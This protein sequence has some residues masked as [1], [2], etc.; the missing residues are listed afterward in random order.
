[1]LSIIMLH[2]FSY[3]F[4][5]RIRRMGE[6]LIYIRTLKMYTW[7]HFFVKRVL[8]SRDQELKHLAVSKKY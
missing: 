4:T 1:M 7:E 8:Q 2:Y 5:H 3:L 6:L